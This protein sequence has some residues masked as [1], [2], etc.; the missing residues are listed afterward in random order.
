M[1]SNYII[2]TDISNKNNNKIWFIIK[3]NIQ[4]LIKKYLI[5]LKITV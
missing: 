4:F 1:F 3:Y 5:N 2:M